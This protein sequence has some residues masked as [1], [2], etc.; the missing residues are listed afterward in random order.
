MPGLKL[1]LLQTVSGIKWICTFS[2]NDAVLPPSGYCG[3]IIP[4]PLSPNMPNLKLG[5]SQIVTGNKIDYFCIFSKSDTVPPPSRYYGKVVP[6]HNLKIYQTSPWVLVFVYHSDFYVFC[7]DALNGLGAF[8]ETE[9]LCISVLRVTSGPRVKLVGCKSALTPR[10]H[11]LTRWF[12]LLAVL[13][14]W[15]RC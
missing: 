6:L 13:R 11:P 12:I 8:M 4:L 9:I 10:S 15:S 1:G 14:R 3:E 7:F 2:K 5:L